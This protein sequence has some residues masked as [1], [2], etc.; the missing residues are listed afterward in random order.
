M[1]STMEREG[2]TDALCFQESAEAA[3][4]EEVR[5]LHDITRMEN[6]LMHRYLKYVML[7]S[8]HQDLSQRLF[9]NSINHMR[10]WDKNSGILIKLGSVIR[11]ENAVKGADGIEKSSSPMPAVYP[12][13][14]RLS[15]LE[16]LIPAEEKLIGAYERLLNLL[17]PGEIR[18]QAGLHLGLNREHLFTQEWLLRNARSIK[19]LR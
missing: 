3:A 17:P 7:F 8:E 12:G 9:K 5:L 14:D 6:E 2:A 10:H 16:T 1:I 13:E 15:A 19:G 18:D 4:R 11:I